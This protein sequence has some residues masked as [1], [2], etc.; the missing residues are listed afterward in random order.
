MRIAHFFQNMTA[1]QD[2]L[3]QAQQQAAQGH[4]QCVVTT[5][6]H[7]SW[8]YPQLLTRTGSWWQFILCR[9]GIGE[10]RQLL[11]QLRTFRPDV[12]H[13]HQANWLGW[14]A[15]R[16]G[17]LL[18]V[19]CIA[20]YHPDSLDPAPRG[21]ARFWHPVRRWRDQ[22]IYNACALTLAPN[23]AGQ[24]ALQAAGIRNTRLLPPGVNLQAFHPW[25]R[26]AAWRAPFGPDPCILLYVGPLEWQHNL[27]LLTQV[28]PGLLAGRP[29]VHFVFVGEGPARAQLT[30]LLPQAHFM[31]PLT[32]KALATAY[33]SSDALVSPTSTVAVRDVALEAM[34]SG[35]PCLVASSSISAE[36]VEQRATGLFFSPA[37][38]ATLAKQLRILTDNPTDRR[39]MGLQA[40]A[41]AQTQGIEEFMARQRVIYEELLVGYPPTPVCPPAVDFAPCDGSL[42]PTA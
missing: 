9:L 11:A 29:H 16:L 35:L 20:T 1:Q 21:S 13:I 5:V 40:H 37:C 4:A 8:P 2:G 10:G 39:R 27:A 18:H 3:I 36:L 22:L 15:T 42:A 30:A 33:A 31:G 23:R 25:F 38:V 32:G 6:K 14:L 7:P 12:L 19:P 41:R 34:A 28:L 17:R 24:R 26:S